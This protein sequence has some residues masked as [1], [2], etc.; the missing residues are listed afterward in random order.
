VDKKAQENTPEMYRMSKFW[1]SEHLNQTS[2]GLRLNKS[3]LQSLRKLEEE[4]SIGTETKNY[5][6]RALKDSKVLEF[7][8]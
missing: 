8:I 3:L 5:K 1:D 4:Q 7:G 2:K 6:T